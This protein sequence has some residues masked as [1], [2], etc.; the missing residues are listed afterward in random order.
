[1]KSNNLI[2]TTAQANDS[3]T[4]LFLDIRKFQTMSG[5]PFA[6]LE[7]LIRCGKLKMIAIGRRRLIHRDE[8]GRLPEILG[9]G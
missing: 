6:A 3:E 7:R 9:A 8:L 4:A 2:S 1:M 5:I